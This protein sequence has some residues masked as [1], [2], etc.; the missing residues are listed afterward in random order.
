M[1][2]APPVIRAVFPANFWLLLSHYGKVKSELGIS[3]YRLQ[4]IGPSTY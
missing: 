1:P 2:V 4:N 3:A